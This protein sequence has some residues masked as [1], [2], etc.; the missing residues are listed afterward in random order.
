MWTTILVRTTH[1]GVCKRRYGQVIEKLKKG[2]KNFEQQTDTC[3]YC[4]FT[5]WTG[6]QY[7]F[8]NTQCVS[9]QK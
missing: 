4:G 5:R 7:K 2:T 9:Y 8:N 6:Y 3:P 1:C